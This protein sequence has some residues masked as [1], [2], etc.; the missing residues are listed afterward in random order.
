MNKYSCSVFVV[1]CG[2]TGVTFGADELSEALEKCRSYVE[3]FFANE[4]RR[5]CILVDI[6]ENCPACEGNGRTWKRVRGGVKEVPC[7]RRG[8][9]CDNGE[10]RRLARVFVKRNDVDPKNTVTWQVA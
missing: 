5:E 4:E 2:H 10:Q 1:L 7:K 3:L 8:K 9:P 6:S